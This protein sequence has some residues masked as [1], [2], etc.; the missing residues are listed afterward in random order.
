MYVIQKNKGAFLKRYSSKKISYSRNKLI[1]KS[2]SRFIIVV[3]YDVL[4]I[5]SQTYSAILQE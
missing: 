4:L 1:K 5:A 3:V 2:V